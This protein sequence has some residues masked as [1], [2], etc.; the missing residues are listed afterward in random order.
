MLA[1]S[2]G[3]GVCPKGAN[4]SFIAL[5][6]KVETSLGLKD[7]RPISLVGLNESCLN[8]LTRVNK[9]LWAEG[10]CLIVC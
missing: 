6:P 3:N 8:L 1:E 2:H 9:L 4:T 10:I 5:I 7:F